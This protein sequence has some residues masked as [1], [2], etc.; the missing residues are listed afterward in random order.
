MG[1]RRRI[2]GKYMDLKSYLEKLFEELDKR[3]ARGIWRDK[4]SRS[5]A[6]YIAQQLF[7]SLIRGGVRGVVFIGLL[8]YGNLTG[9]TKNM[10]IS[11]ST[12]SEFARKF[13]EQGLFKKIRVENRTLYLATRKGFTVFE[14]LVK[15]VSKNVKRLDHD[16]KMT[17]YIEPIRLLYILAQT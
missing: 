11:Y 4:Y 14:E 3:E 1:R 5:E 17:I 2:S 16:T 12:A 9:L 7:D 8:H 15:L 6:R 13:V 10:N